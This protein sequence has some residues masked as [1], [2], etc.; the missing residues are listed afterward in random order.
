MCKWM[1]STELDIDR[2]TDSLIALPRMFTRLTVHMRGI[3]SVLLTF[4]VSLRRDTVQ[5]DGLH[6]GHIAK[7]HLRDVQRTDDVRPSG[8]VGL[9]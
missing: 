7:P 1:D 8:R 2:L 4:A 9:L 5:V 3:F 6:R